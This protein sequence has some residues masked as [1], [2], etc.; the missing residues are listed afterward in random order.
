V[1]FEAAPVVGDV[2]EPEAE[3]R[4]LDVVAG[5]LLAPVGRQRE[6]PLDVAEIFN[7]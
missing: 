1:P 2:T 5:P 7:L 6:A 3:E 4:I